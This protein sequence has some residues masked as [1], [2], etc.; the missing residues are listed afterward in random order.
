MKQHPNILYYHSHDTGRYIQPY[1]YQVPTPN[2]QQLAE[3]GVLF[4]RAF[5]AAPT[6]SPSRAGL[7]TGCAAHSVGM[8]GLAHR[9][10]SLTDVSRTMVTYLREV[11][12]ETC[13][14]GI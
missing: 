5:C 1:G 10:F 11:G 2:L 9:G 6:C 8:L 3:E 7:L 13:L 4:R 14:C 12:Y